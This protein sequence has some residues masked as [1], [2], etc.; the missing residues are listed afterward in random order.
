MHRAWGIC[1][2][3]YRCSHLYRVL[4]TEMWWD[5]SHDWNVKIDE[6]KPFR[7]DRQGRRE[8]GALDIKDLLE[9]MEMGDELTKSL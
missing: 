6:C 7:K 1:K 8:G 9:S 5:G 4:I 2:K 3:S